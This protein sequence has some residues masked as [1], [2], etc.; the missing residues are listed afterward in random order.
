MHRL[1]QSNRSPMNST[2]GVK[3]AAA[4]H[5]K[6]FLGKTELISADLVR[7]RQN[8]G[9]I[10]TKVIRFEQNQNLASPKTFDLLRLGRLLLTATIPEND[11]DLVKPTPALQ[12]WVDITK[13][14]I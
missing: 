5:S 12:A 9:D 2:V 11:Q 10:W 6:N 3:D 13:F 14:N 4:F 1:L 8:E 7:F